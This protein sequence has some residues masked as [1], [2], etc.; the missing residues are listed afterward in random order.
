MI[1]VVALSAADRRLLRERWAQHGNSHRRMLAAL[2]DVGADDAR[3]RLNALRTVEKT[4]N[5]DLAEIC[6]RHARR[7]D[8]LTHPIERL[9]IEFITE[10]RHTEADAQLWV[11][12]DR[13]RQVRELMDGKFGSELKS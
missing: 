6:H 2:A 9:V 4:F 12:P 10:E 3:A 7:N 13:V 5:L 1:H 11:L 8:A